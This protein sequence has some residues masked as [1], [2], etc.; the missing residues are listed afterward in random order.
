M[1]C[2]ESHN[3][4]DLTKGIVFAAVR[5]GRCFQVTL[6][7]KKTVLVPC[8]K[9][10]FTIL[11]SCLRDAHPACDLAP[12]E[13]PRGMEGSLVTQLLRVIAPMSCREARAFR[14][15]RKWLQGFVENPDLSLEELLMF[16]SGILG[17]MIHIET[18]WRSQST[19]SSSFTIS[20]KSLP[21]LRRKIPTSSKRHESGYGVL[22]TT[23][24]THRSRS[25]SGTLCCS[26]LSYRSDD[27]N[28]RLIATTRANECGHVEG[29]VIGQ[30]RLQ[31]QNQRD[32]Q[33]GHQRLLRRTPLQH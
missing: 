23:Y 12:W 22:Q 19:T 29:R 14:N 16:F 33:V 2:H 8:N 27:R 21:V 9:Q 6:G 18:T 13:T 25:F 15:A 32:S 10:E 17:P 28:R 4:I 3:V 26:L 24:P 7:T 11:S 20:I 1:C 30:R 5:Y 31:P